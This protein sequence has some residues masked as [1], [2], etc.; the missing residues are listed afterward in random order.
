MDICGWIIEITLREDLLRVIMTGIDRDRESGQ[1]T[2]TYP[3]DDFLTAL[4]ERGP[5]VGT[6]EIADI[7][8]CN[9]DTA[10]RRLRDLEEEN[11]IESRKIGMVRLWSISNR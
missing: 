1:Y 4:E 10:Y 3:R 5:D 11:E 2:E 7:V 9:R 6:Q 8:G